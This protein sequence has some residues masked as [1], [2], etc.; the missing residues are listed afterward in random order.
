MQQPH[1]RVRVRIRRA[2]SWMIFVR[3]ISRQSSGRGDSV[4]QVLRIRGGCDR[5]TAAAVQ[6]RRNGV[7]WVLRGR[8]GCDRTSQSSDRR[9]TEDALLK[10]IEC[11]DFRSKRGCANRRDDCPGE[12]TFLEPAHTRLTTICSCRHTFS[13]EDST[14]CF[15][16]FAAIERDSSRRSRRPSANSGH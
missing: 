1:A 10:L 7:G 12:N 15:P 4:G 6:D 16:G 9:S 2:G 5:L 11:T 13:R 8:R 14:M 3:L